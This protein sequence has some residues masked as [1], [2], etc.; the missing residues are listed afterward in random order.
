MLIR[1][2]TIA[3]LAAPAATAPGSDKPSP[4]WPAF[5]G[6]VVYFA[7][8]GGVLHAVDLKTGQARW[9]YKAGEDGFE[10]TPLVAGGRVFIGDLGGVFHAVN[11][12]DGKKAWTIETASSIHSSA[13]IEGD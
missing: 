3:F 13:N 12:A 10:T 7:D 9:T 8:G 6:G 11:A 5:A 1:L 4:D 2:L